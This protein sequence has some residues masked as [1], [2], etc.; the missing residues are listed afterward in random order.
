MVL[1]SSPAR[2]WPVPVPELAK[3]HLSGSF[4]IAATNAL[5]SAGAS[6][7]V[8]TKTMGPWDSRLTAL[9]SR[10]ISGCARPKTMGPGTVMSV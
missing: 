1:N 10:P 4:F 8:P 3:S 9:S 5:R 6:L 7:A 2:C